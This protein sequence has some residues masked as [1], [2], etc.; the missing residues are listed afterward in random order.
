QT[1]AQTPPQLTDVFMATVRLTNPKSS[2]TAFILVR[3]KKNDEQRDRL[4]LVTAAHVLEKS[5]GDEVTIGFRRKD[6]EGG[7]AKLP[8]PLKVRDGGKPLWAKH[9]Q[10]DVAGI[11]IEM[12]QGV[13]SPRLTLEQLATL[14]DIKAVEPGDM[15]NCVTYPHAPVFEPNQTGFPV[16]RMGCM[17]GYPSVSLAKEPTFLV[18]YNSFE[19]DSGGPVVWKNTALKTN[20]GAAGKPTIKILGLVQGQHLFKQRFELPYESGESRKSLGLGIVLNAQAIR[21][22]ILQLP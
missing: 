8:V 15:V 18:D 22:T 14:D 19:G 12:P 17:A 7:F 21:E 11:E 16:V 9:P 2:A 4:A 10:H 1:P 13:E 20:D 3:P 5:E 6:T